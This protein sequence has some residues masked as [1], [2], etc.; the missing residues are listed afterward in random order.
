MIKRLKT[1]IEQLNKKLEFRSLFLANMSHEIRTPLNGIIGIVDVLKQ[2][3]ANQCDIQQYIDIIEKSSLNLLNIVNDVLDLSKIEAGKIEFNI[4]NENIRKLIFE[5]IELN[6]IHALNNENQIQSN[7]SLNLPR[8]IL[9]DKNRIIQILNNLI[10]NANKCTI[11]GT[12]KLNVK[13]LKNKLRF[14]VIDTG[15]GI[16]EESLKNIFNDFTQFENKFSNNNKGTGLG[17]SI[18]KQLIELMD[19]NIHIESQLNKGTI[20]SFEIP[21][22]TN[23]KINR[24]HS[25]VTN[26]ELNPLN[27]HI[28]IVE[29]KYINQ[30]VVGMMLNKMNCTFDIAANGQE[31]VDLYH[32]SKHDIVLMDIRMPVM[33]GKEATM[34]LKERY[35]EE[36][37]I[38]G[39]SAESMEGDK[40]KYMRLGMIDYIPKPV[41]IYILNDKLTSFKRPKNNLL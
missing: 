23:N 15:C 17:L 12:I 25:N 1:E 31:A 6:Q 4:K 9:I 27:L 14:E 26:T 13:K 2:G 11:N 35:G 7:I 40:E 41:S 29:D 34:I 24:T 30:T 21:L 37:T 32:P 39:L 8:N 38:I 10:S 18:C 22:I 20:V 19:G 33:D 3:T 36:I 16:S 28:L 5:T